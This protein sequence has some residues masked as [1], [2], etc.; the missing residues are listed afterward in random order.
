MRITEL[1][2]GQAVYMALN[3]FFE[4]RTEPRLRLKAQQLGDDFAHEFEQELAVLKDCGAAHA[5]RR[6]FASVSRRK[7][8]LHAGEIAQNS[9][10]GVFAEAD[11]RL[12]KRRKAIW[13]EYLAQL[14]GGNGVVDVMDTSDEAKCA[15]RISLSN[16]R[17]VFLRPMMGGKLEVYWPIANGRQGQP[18]EGVEATATFLAYLAK[19]N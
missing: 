17:E 16:H 19:E 7:N 10:R 11:K 1:L 8:I 14:R 3:R 12:T 13:N 18:C 4:R 6:A 2:S 5:S 9:L 15:A